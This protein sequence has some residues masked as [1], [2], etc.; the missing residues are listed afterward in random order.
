MATK[1]TKKRRFKSVVW[2]YFCKLDGGKA[3][4]N[5]CGAEL[6]SLNS[7]S[8]LRNHLSYLHPAINLN[9]TPATSSLC[10]S[11]GKFSYHY[12]SITEDIDCTLPE[13]RFSDL[14]AKLD[15]LTSTIKSFVELCIVDLTPI[16]LLNGKG[17]KSFCR[18][19]NPTCK[20]P[21]VKSAKDILEKLYNANKQ[22]LIDCLKNGEH[23]SFTTDAW[24]NF[25]NE[26]Y[27][28]LSVHFID[29]YWNYQNR[30]LY[31][32]EVKDQHPRKDIATEI[33][34]VLVNFKISC[35]NIDCITVASK[36]NVDVCSS[37]LGYPMIKCIGHT[38]KQ[39]VMAGLSIQTIHKT[40]ESIRQIVSYICNSEVATTAFKEEQR[41]LNLPTHPLI[42]SSL[43]QWD[44]VYFMLSRASEQQL[45][46]L[47][48]IQNDSILSSEES[49]RLEISEKDWKVVEE[50]SI[51]LEPLHLAST[52]ICAESYPFS[53]MVYPL[54]KGLVTIHM[55][56]TE[57]DSIDIKE[58][59]RKV[60]SILSSQYLTISDNEICINPWV[61]ASALDPRYK[62]IKF[63]E[64]EQREQTWN[65]VLGMLTEIK[66]KHAT[67]SSS[68]LEPRAKRQ[69]SSA[70]QFLL[71]DFYDLGEQSSASTEAMFKQESVDYE[72]AE[73]TIID[74][75]RQEL[76]SYKLE[77]VV[78][79]AGSTESLNSLQWW[80]SH[81]KRY[82][83]L[84][85]LAKR[86]LAI[87]GT[88]VPSERMFSVEGNAFHQKR[89]ALDPDTVDKLLFMHDVPRK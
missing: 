18:K 42:E 87:P 14:N 28:T 50:I 19:L 8:S 15:E 80:K 83:T 20:L 78:L 35:L 21:S 40:I 17:F 60:S 27:L 52:V 45:A 26:K 48:V 11:S 16:S 59:K 43:T 55:K 58:F 32:Y 79:N 86:F 70:M 9:G 67:D 68:N 63:L 44:S 10:A 12:P 37:E 61:I 56:P 24:S 7:T 64:E 38:L 22:D 49:V 47:S 73:E 51:A 29:E 57:K 34:D 89:A 41:H 25:T 33:N 6:V 36:L 85:K 82:P 65:H 5:I 74:E 1:T 39:S 72:T 71:G 2:H 46:I 23:V 88:A 53:S 76:E 66:L 84:S 54:V 75:A 62:Q 3:K 4:C 30:V 81:F 69:K 13:N 77:K 31:T